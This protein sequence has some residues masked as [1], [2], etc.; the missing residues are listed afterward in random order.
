MSEPITVS[1]AYKA[2]GSDK[3]YNLF[4]KPKGTGFIVEFTWGRRG[5]ELTYSLKT[6][7][8]VSYEDAV[9]ILRK[10]EKSKRSG[11]YSDAEHA[12]KPFAG[13]DYADRKTQHAPQLLNTVEGEELDALLDDDGYCAQPKHDGER[14]MIAKKGDEVTGINRSGLT[15]ALP[16]ELV[17]DAKQLPDGVYDG[18]LVGSTLHVFDLVQPGTYQSRLHALEK[19][20]N[21]PMRHILRVETAYTSDAKINLMARVQAENGEGIVLKDLKAAYKPGRPASGGPQRKFKFVETASCIVLRSNTGKRSVMLGVVEGDATIEVGSCTIPANHNIPEAGTVVEVRYLYAYR[22]GA[23]FQP[24]YLG[25]RTDIEA[26]DC[27][28]DQLKF[29]E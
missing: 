11:G 22:G 29:T 18:E 1:L 14:V 15:R 2:D 6:P 27:T 23:L 9:K 13:A 24:V 28:V 8:P 21:K 25:P 26:K 12:G 10:Q 20:L 3:V 7:E 19:N 4:V 16:Q 5:A 17:D